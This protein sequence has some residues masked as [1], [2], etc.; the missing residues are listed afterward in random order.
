MVREPKDHPMKKI[1]IPIDFSGHTEITC[2]YAIEAAKS[3]NA[4]LRLFHTC[5]D[6][7]IIADSSFPEALDMSTMYNEEVLKEV[8]N[9]AERNM[10]ELRKKTEQEIARRKLSG[11][12]VSVSLTGGEIEHELKEVYEEF[13]PDL[14]IMGTTGTGKTPNF[15]GKVST[16][17]INNSRV[18]VMVIPGISRFLGFEK[19]ML[20]ADLTKANAGS[21]RT[22][23]EIFSA[24]SPTLYCVH[25]HKKTDKDDKMEKMNQLRSQFEKEEKSGLI[26]FEMKEIMEDT[27]QTINRFVTDFGIELIAFQPYR[28]GILYR[29]FSKKI[30]KKNL[31]ATNIP[32]LAVPVN[33]SA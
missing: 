10:N 16:H 30:S 31:F 20:A 2:S 8:L 6:Q 28:H 7:I 12:S 18:P 14:V 25:F 3:G 23:L 11:I 26:R 1:L 5:F 24:F 4:E 32:L 21:V 33:P 19:I 15:W 9:Q 27:Q 17:I 13:R 29:M 22:V